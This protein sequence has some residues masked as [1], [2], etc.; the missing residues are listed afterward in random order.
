MSVLHDYSAE[1]VSL[2]DVLGRQER[3]VVPDYQRPY[4]WKQSEVEDL[5]A[6][7]MNHYM[8]DSKSRS[9]G[10]LLGPIVTLSEPSSKEHNIVDGQQR[11]VTLTLLLCAIRDSVRK[12]EAQRSESDKAILENLTKEINALVVDRDN[13]G[14]ITLND[15]NGTSMLS[16]IQESDQPLSNLKQRRRTSRHDSVKRLIENYELLMHETDSL[17]DKCNLAST[18]V[19]LI[20]AVQTLRDIVNDVKDRSFFVRINIFNEDYSH[21]VFQSL[22]SKGLPLNE[23]DII[24]SYLMKK[25]KSDKPSFKWSE[26]KWDEI[27]NRK[28]TKPDLLLYDSLLSRPDTTSSKDPSKKYLYR[29]VRERCKTGDDAKVYLKDLEEDAEIIA[30]LNRPSDLPDSFPAELKHSFFGIDQIGARYIRRPIIAACREWGIMDRNTALLVDCLLKF[31]FMYRTI[32]EGNIDTLKK[33]TR[34]TTRQIVSGDKLNAIIPT[35]LDSDKAA[36]SDNVDEELFK[37]KFKDEIQELKPGVAKYILMSLEHQLANPGG[38]SLTVAGSNLELEHIFPAQPSKEWA[39]SGKL[40]AHR[41]RLGNLT[42]MPSSW[43]KRLSNR[44][45]VDK[46]S[47]WKENTDCYEKSD[48][49]LNQLYLKGYENWTL[50]EIADREEKLCILAFDVWTL[51]PYRKMVGAR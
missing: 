22:N 46:K 6:D 48:L 49:K 28:D 41:C 37:K 16:E 32:G 38:I 47:G 11:L 14:L 35:I 21:Q 26:A 50:K 18:D 31:F 20:D 4:M 12:H 8:E 3:Y 51:K 29:F 27:M 34:N 2:A 23:A 42:M 30:K 36:V 19:A 40:E 33:I 39:D 9:D 10:Y 5:W 45:F 1:R 15:G 7:L 44:S 43:N 13:K 24:K 17:C 25:L